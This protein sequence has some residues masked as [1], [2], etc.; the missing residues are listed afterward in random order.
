MTTK[1]IGREFGFWVLMAVSIGMAYKGQ[2]EASAIYF[3][4]AILFNAIKSI[5]NDNN[6]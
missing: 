3:V 1:P 5:G 2:T 4:G 6:G